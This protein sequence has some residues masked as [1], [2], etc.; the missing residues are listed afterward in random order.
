MSR[1]SRKLRR[2]Q[3]QAQRHERKARPTHKGRSGR[4]G[5]MHERKTPAQTAPTGARV[6]GRSIGE[7]ARCPKCGAMPGESHRHDV[8]TG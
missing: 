4:T 5:A 6:T 2:Q 1:R 8:A 7:S 3:R